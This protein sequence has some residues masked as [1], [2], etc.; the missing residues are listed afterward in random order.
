MVSDGPQAAGLRSLVADRTSDLPFC[1]TLE[2][3]RHSMP[4][5]KPVVAVSQGVNL[6]V[7][8][9]WPVNS[10]SNEQVHGVPS[11]F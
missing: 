7:S 10:S 2:A 4:A 9:R 8:S 11:G 1:D 6:V 5:W 3:V